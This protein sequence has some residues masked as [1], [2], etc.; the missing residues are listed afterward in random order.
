MKVPLRWFFLPLLLLPL[1]LILYLSVVSAWVYPSLWEGGLSVERWK[2]LFDESN[3]L[4]KS[5]G[6]S[7]FISI[8]ISLTSTIFGFCFSAYLSLSQSLVSWYRIAFF[9]YLI[10][11]VS[12]AALL[13]YY[14]VRFNL[15][16]SLA[17]VW[18]AQLL[19]ILPF[20]VIIFSSFWSRN[21]IDL[22]RQGLIL[23]AD[24]RVAFIRI[25]WPLAKPW[26]VFSL[27]LCFL[28]SWFEYGIT[29]LIGVGK[30]RTLTIDTMLY[31]NESNLFQAALASCL[32]VLPV[33]LILLTGY[34]ASRKISLRQ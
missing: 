20:S 19:F 12:F 23:G 4:R 9:P 26:F 25:V 33:L 6:L 21:T 17:G 10:A 28:A 5:F 15:N 7:L 2:Y 29:G 1:I 31:V 8:G 16:G 18:L 34:F 22:Y 3:H 24:P 11:P 32:L 13:Q 14:F 27:I 30:V